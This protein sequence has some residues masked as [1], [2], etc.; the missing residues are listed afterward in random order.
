V[1]KLERALRR[2]LRPE[3]TQRARALASAMT[4]QPNAAARAAA[5][6]EARFAGPVPVF[7]A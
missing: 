5:L 6:I 7:Y 2:I 3:A 1:A 4:S